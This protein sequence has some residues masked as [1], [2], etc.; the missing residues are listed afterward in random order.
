M[1]AVDVALYFAFLS[2]HEWA[3]R[4]FNVEVEKNLLWTGLVVGLSAVL[5]IRTN[6]ATVGN[7]QIGGEYAYT[8]SRALLI[9]ILNRTRAR[10]RRAFITKYRPPCKD[11]ASYPKYFTSLEDTLKTL[12]QGSDFRAEIEQQLATLRKN[13]NDPN[14]DAAAREGLTGLVYDYFGPKEVKSW[15]EDSD[16][17]NK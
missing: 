16:F 10:A 13:G 2:N 11:V 17:G 12:A 4:A 6:L 15:S 3:K 14:A 1:G 9:D 7:F 8:W 5:I